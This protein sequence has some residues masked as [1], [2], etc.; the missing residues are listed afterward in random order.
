MVHEFGVSFP[1]SDQHGVRKRYP[2]E[3]LYFPAP[4]VLE[5]EI[6]VFNA[7]ESPRLLFAI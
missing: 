5:E 1:A 7:V 4:V 2:F 6:P 3:V